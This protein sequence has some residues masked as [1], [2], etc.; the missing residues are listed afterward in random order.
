MKQSA[1]GVEKSLRQGVPRSSLLQLPFVPHLL[2]VT[3][4][5]S[6]LCFFFFFPPF[7]NKFFFNSRAW[8]HCTALSNA[9]CAGEGALLGKAKAAL[10]LFAAGG[11][12][13][14]NLPPACERGN[15]W[16]QQVVSFF[17]FF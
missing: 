15:A 8:E 5:E 7:N 3:Q 12:W 10:N 17:F 16:Q 9:E 1:L 14:T 4:A 13:S 2:A 11:M 6:E